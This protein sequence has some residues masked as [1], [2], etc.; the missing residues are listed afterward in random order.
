MVKCMKGKA[1]GNS[2]IP[3]KS[4]CSKPVVNWP[5]V[6]EKGKSCGYSCIS[7][8][9]TCHKGDPYDHDSQ[10]DYETVNDSNSEHGLGFF[11]CEMSSSGEMSEYTDETVSCPVTVQSCPAA[12]Y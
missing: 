2:C 5:R 7:K 9:L 12:C 10:Y 11:S 3:K 6:C 4:K 1:C 8:K